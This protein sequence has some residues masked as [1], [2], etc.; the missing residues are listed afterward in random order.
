M[1]A[2]ASRSRWWVAPGCQSP[3]EALLLDL[4]RAAGL[5][6]RPQ[7]HLVRLCEWSGLHRVD[8]WLPELA[9]AVEVQGAHH[10]APGV[11]ETDKRKRAALE[12]EDIEV[13]EVGISTGEIRRVAGEL[14]ARPRG[15][16]R[17]LRARR[18]KAASVEQTARWRRNAAARRKATRARRRRDG[19]CITCGKRP[20][21]AI[22]P[23]CTPCMDRDRWISDELLEAFIA[24]SPAMLPGGGK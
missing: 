13:V 16:W 8:A 5:A 6:V 19:Y 18:R 3:A 20:P 22:G 9:V 11:R 1:N 14:A 21:N 12:A 23:T 17:P 2:G 4:L 15:A 7:V 24:A 10:R